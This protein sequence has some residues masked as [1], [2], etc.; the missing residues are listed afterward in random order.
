MQMLLSIAAQPA[1]FGLCATRPDASPLGPLVDYRGAPSRLPAVNGRQC[2]VYLVLDEAS[3]G[4]PSNIIQFSDYIAPV[5]E[6][7]K[8]LKSLRRFNLDKD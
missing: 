1:L 7:W 5:T 3:A 8:F 2:S 6:G 4:L